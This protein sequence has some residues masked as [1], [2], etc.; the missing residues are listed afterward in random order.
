M[1]I[2][3]LQYRGNIG[4][5]EFAGFVI[6]APSGLAARLLAAKASGDEGQK[7]WVTEAKTSCVLLGP[8]NNAEEYIANGEIILRDYRAG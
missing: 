4:Y 2:Y 1:N 6:V 8:A 3:L 5:D 7:C